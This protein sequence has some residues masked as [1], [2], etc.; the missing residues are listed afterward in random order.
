MF[1]S[2]I[3]NWELNTAKRELWCWD[4]RRNKK[5]RRSGTSREGPPL[6]SDRSERDAG[7]LLS[8]FSVVIFPIMQ[9][10]CSFTGYCHLD[11]V[12]KFSL[13]IPIQFLWCQFWEFDATSKQ[14]FLH[15]WFSLSPSAVW[16]Q[17]F[18]F[19]MK[20]LWEKAIKASCC[21]ND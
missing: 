19:C 4:V 2:S 15:K 6:T 17:M 11:G 21:K 3:Q 5:T 1:C 20:K 10:P 14:Y 16:L 18:W 13:L 8:Q 12:C 7:L 9:H